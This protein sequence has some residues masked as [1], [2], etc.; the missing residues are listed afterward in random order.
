MILAIVGVHKHVFVKTAEFVLH[1]FN[2]FFAGFI[3]PG[4]WV[5]GLVFVPVISVE[6][7]L[8]FRGLFFLRRRNKTGPRQYY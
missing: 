8:V 1:S 5:C 6:D 3:I 4:E 2:H 7:H